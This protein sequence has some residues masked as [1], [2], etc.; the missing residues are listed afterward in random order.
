MYLGARWSLKAYYSTKIDPICFGKRMKACPIFKFAF[1]IGKS[2]RN[3]ICIGKQ[4]KACPIFKFAF[5]KGKSNRNSICIGKQMKTCRI[6]K[7]AFY[8]GKSNRNLICV[9]KLMKISQIWKVFEGDF[10]YKKSK[11]S[12]SQIFKICKNPPGFQN[13]L[14]PRPHRGT[15]ARAKSDIF[16]KKFR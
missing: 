14:D 13:I 4:M 5:Y 9:G 7:F 10:R 15:N 12:K 6:S 16:W 8:I 2:N 1:Y 11:E 3:S